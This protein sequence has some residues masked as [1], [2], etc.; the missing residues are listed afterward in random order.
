MVQQFILHIENEHVLIV[1]NPQ[2][3]VKNNIYI[4]AVNFNVINS[5]AQI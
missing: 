1:A 5:S 3:E 4:I 2:A